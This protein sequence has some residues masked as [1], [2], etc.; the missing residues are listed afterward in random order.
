[1]A[2][3]AL[4]GKKRLVGNKVSHANNRNKMVQQPNVQRKRIFIPELGRWASLNV[5][6]RALRTIDRIGLLAF[7][8]KQGLDIDKLIG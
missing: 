3:C 1:M 8:R 6:T 7:A 4:T 5:S 2:T